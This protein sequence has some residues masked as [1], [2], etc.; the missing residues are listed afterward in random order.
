MNPVFLLLISLV[1]ATSLTQSI[2]YLYFTIQ[3]NPEL[4]RARNFGE[5]CCAWRGLQARL[6]PL[7][8]AW[9]EDIFK[10]FYGIHPN[11]VRAHQLPTK[12][13][14]ACTGVVKGLQM[15]QLGLWICCSFFRECESPI[16][17]LLAEASN[18]NI[19]GGSF[20]LNPLGLKTQESKSR[21]RIRHGN[22]QLNEVTWS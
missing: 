11:R 14:I 15:W 17:I 20:M 7:L 4:P 2:N 9:H 21:R 19:H 8:A 16:V 1:F 13:S 5:Q 12:Q 10:D 3:C 22:R 18:N 6:R